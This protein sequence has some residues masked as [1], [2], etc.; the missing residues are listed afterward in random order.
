[1]LELRDFRFLPLLYLGLI[2]KYKVQ[3]HS[4]EVYEGRIQGKDIRGRAPL[5]WINRVREL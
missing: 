4:N 1:M 3:Q 2:M 5:R